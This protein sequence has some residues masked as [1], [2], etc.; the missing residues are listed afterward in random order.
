MYSLN[1]NVVKPPSLLPPATER[2][3]V[4]LAGSIEMGKAEDWQ[5]AFYE[6]CC[7]TPITF[8]NPRR[9][10][11]DS[12]WEQ[13]KE[14][15]NF[16]GQVEWELDGLEQAA[17]IVFYFAPDTLAPVTLAE[18]GLFAQSGKAI[19]CC[20]EG[21]WRKGNVDIMCE[22]YG[23]QQVDTLSELIDLVRERFSGES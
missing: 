2:P 3:C 23:V 20:P 12:T 15:P 13:R 18:F 4:F 11:W 9:D 19:V 7:N 10:N 14:N 21:Y 22:R 17:M 16:R 5:A 1:S 8:L 6:A